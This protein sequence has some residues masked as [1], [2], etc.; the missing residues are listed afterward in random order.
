MTYKSKF[1]GYLIEVENAREKVARAMN[2]YSAGRGSVSAVNRANRA[3]QNAHEA[4]EQCYAD[5]LLSVSDHM[6]QA[7]SLYL[8]G[9]G[10]LPQ[11]PAR[12][13]GQHHEERQ[14]GVQI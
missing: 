12:P 7:L 6:R 14:N 4:A 10:L 1:D 9:H 2:D 13:N 3:L 11:R 8:K 5:Q